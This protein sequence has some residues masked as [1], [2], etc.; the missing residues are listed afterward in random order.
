VTNSKL[1]TYSV[2]SYKIEDGAIN[3]DKILS[4]SVITSSLA[5]SAVTTAK[6]ADDSVTK[7][8]LNANCA[9]DGLTVD[10]AG[11]IIPS[12]YQDHFELNMYTSEIMLKDDSI[13]KAKINADIA[14]N[15]LVQNVTGALEVNADGTSLVISSDV[16]KLNRKEIIGILSFSGGGRSFITILNTAGVTV[17]LSQA[18]TGI[19]SLTVS[20]AIL[21][22]GKTIA[23]IQPQNAIAEYIGIR[24]HSDTVLRIDSIDQSSS[25]IDLAGDFY[26]HI[27][28][29]P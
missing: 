13:T 19:Y 1:G 12:L 14:G 11:A 29:F 25:G 23:F 28:I 4:G 26:I 5:N 7:D 6:L 3:S 16:L 24:R 21:L 17:S 8:K 9:G 22:T 18:D 10:I 2:T 20:S 15:G 27:S